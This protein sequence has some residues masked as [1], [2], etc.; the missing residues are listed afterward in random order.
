[1]GSASRAEGMVQ[2]DKD[3]EAMKRN[4]ST[5]SRI[6]PAGVIETRPTNF[7]TT[8]WIDRF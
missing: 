6:T 5:K 2:V 7:A 3:V 4:R 8:L 1:M